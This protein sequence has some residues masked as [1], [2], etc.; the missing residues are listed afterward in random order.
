MKIFR[1]KVLLPRLCFYLVLKSKFLIRQSI[2]SNRLKRTALSKIGLKAFKPVLIL[3][4]SDFQQQSI[5][6][7]FSLVVSLKPDEHF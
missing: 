6:L 2:E 3:K 7:K 4:E 5:F 1:K